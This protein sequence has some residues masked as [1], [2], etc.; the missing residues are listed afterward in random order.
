MENCSHCGSPYDPSNVNI[1]SPIPDG[2][3]FICGTQL[4]EEKIAELLALYAPQEEEA[5]AE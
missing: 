4:S 3:C 5:P 2:M 1:P